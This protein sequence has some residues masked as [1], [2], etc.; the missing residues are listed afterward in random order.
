MNRPTQRNWGKPQHPAMTYQPPKQLRRL[1]AI[2]VLLVSALLVLGLWTLTWFAAEMW[3]KSSITDWAEAQRALGAEVGYETLETSGFPSRI[4]F[5]ITKPTY[6][7]PLMGQNVEWS[8][9]RLVVG[10]R[11]WTPWRLHL[12][13]PGR[14][15]LK[16]GG[17][18]LNLSGQ[19]ESL[20]AD[21][22]AGDVWP[23]SLD[24]SIAGLELSDGEVVGVDDLTAHFGYA[25]DGTGLK[26]LAKGTNLTL[27]HSANMVLGNTVQNFDVALSMSDPLMPGAVLEGLPRWRAG[28]GAMEIERFK[29][30]SGPLGLTAAGTLAL[31]DALQPMGAFTAKIEGLFQVL[32]I[33]RVR[34]FVRGSDAVIATMALSA[35]SKRPK[36]GGASSINLSVTVQDG[37]LSLGPIPI[38]KMPHV[39]WG[40]SAEAPAPVAAPKPPRDYKDVPPVL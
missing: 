12:D 18:V 4:T 36:N 13:A 20:S 38:M 26:I 37:M 22:V 7:G 24:L 3:A 9:E 19:A 27:P 28:G 33:L 6:T 29:V 25:P 1:K 39:V 11:P 15:D 35:L 34:G 16:L 23:Q 21:L 31:N 5:T 17:G 2:M 10:T 32:E 14:H 8:G 30:R 40:I